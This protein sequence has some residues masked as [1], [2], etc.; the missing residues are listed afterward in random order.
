MAYQDLNTEITL[1]AQCFGN[2][3]SEVQ[4]K[5]GNPKLL[6]K[7]RSWKNGTGCE[8]CYIFLVSLLNDKHILAYMWVEI[9]SFIISAMLIN[10]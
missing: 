7:V 4:L 1:T 9:L 8:I 3:Y 10:V 2:Q 5:H 6:V